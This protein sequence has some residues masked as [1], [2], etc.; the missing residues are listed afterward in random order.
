MNITENMVADSPASAAKK[1]IQ[2]SNVNVCGVGSAAAVGVASTVVVAPKMAAAVIVDF[3]VA[4]PAS[5]GPVSLVVTVPGCERAP[6][7]APGAAEADGPMEDEAGAK[8]ADAKAAGLALSPLAH[9]ATV[10]MRITKAGRAVRRMSCVRDLSAF[11]AL[12]ILFTR[13]RA[14]PLRRTCAAMG[15]MTQ[16]AD[17]WC[18]RV[19]ALL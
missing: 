19:L 6:G 17:T 4:L 8:A 10:P 2:S 3:T 12:S 13:F 9:P 1:A 15:K 11:N 5:P 18:A 16:Q 14:S 7:P